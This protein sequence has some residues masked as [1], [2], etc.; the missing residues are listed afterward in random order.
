MLT[1]QSF[2][3][4]RLMTSPHTWLCGEVIHFL[5]CKSCRIDVLFVRLWFM[6]AGLRRLYTIPCP[7]PYH[8][9]TYTYTYINTHRLLPC[10]RGECWLDKAWRWMLNDIT[11][12]MT[13]RW[14]HSFGV[15]R[16]GR[17]G[18]LLVLLWSIANTHTHTPLT[19]KRGMLTRQSCREDAKWFH[20]TRN[21]VLT[22]FAL[23]FALS[24]QYLPLEVF[25]HLDVAVGLFKHFSSYRFIPCCKADLSE[26]WK[27][28]H[29]HTQRIS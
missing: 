17:I 11:T 23:F 28:A 26:K 24:Y 14:S 18:V 15:F 1:R 3:R 20:N 7:M 29:A 27:H 16:F 25:L 19:P 21:C 10:T 13:V 9:H 6:F 5:F 8:I 12:H 4:G 2:Q 22:S